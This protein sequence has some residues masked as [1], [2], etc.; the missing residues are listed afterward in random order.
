M[1]YKNHDHTEKPKFLLKRYYEDTQMAIINYFYFLVAQ[2]V[3]CSTPPVNGV[4][5]SA[6]LGHPS[7]SQVFCPLGIVLEQLQQQQKAG[8]EVLRDE[9]SPVAMLTV[10]IPRL[11]ARCCRKGKLFNLCNLIHFETNLFLFC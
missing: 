7:P 8:N 10:H 5:F 4:L 6:A 3:I 1:Q 9:G 2:F 11:K